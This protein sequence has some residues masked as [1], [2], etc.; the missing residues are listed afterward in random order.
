VISMTDILGRKPA[1][2]AAA[3][4]TSVMAAVEASPTAPQDSHIRMQEL[5]P[6][7]TLP[8]LQAKLNGH[9]KGAAGLVGLFVKP[10]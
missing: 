10:E 4:S 5:P 2:L 9:T 8:E 1:L 7:L 3:A 6:G